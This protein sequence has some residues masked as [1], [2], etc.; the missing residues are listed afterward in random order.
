[1]FNGLVQTCKF[2]NTD[3]NIE[4]RLCPKWN[5]WSSYY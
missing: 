4:W 3:W 2:L 5:P 1:M